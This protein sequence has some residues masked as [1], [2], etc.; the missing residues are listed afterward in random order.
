[1]PNGFGNM[2][3]LYVLEGVGRAKI[4]KRL[5][6][7][8]GIY[9]RRVVSRPVKVTAMGYIEQRSCAIVQIPAKIGHM[10][11]TLAQEE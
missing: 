9:S 7:L 1:M 2:Y 4:K 5:D 6:E 3:G 11:V 8:T 10:A